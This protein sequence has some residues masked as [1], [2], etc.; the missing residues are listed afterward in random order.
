MP[1]LTSEALYRYRV[2][3]AFPKSILLATDAGFAPE[4][5]PNATV[6]FQGKRMR[7]AGFEWQA[8]DAAQVEYPLLALANSRLWRRQE[9]PELG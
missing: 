8:S 5:A 9:R 2:T 4:P 6:L 3:R 1:H 7:A